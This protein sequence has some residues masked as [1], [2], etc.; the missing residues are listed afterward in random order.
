MDTMYL[1][2]VVIGIAFPKSSTCYHLRDVF[3]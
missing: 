2:L 1:Y 3:A